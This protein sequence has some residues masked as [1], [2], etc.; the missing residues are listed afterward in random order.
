MTNSVGDIDIDFPSRDIALS[1][2]DYTQASMIKNENLEKHNTG[3]YFHYVP[4]DPVKNLCSIDYETAERRGWFKM[5]LLNVWVYEQVKDEKHLLDLLNREIDW[6]VFEQK[7]FVKRLIHLGNYSDLVSSLKPKNINEIAIIL[8]LIRPGKKHLIDRCKHKGFNSITNE[9]WL[10][11]EDREY[12]FK[13][14]HS[15]GYAALVKVHASLLIEQASE[16]T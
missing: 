13:K 1:V 14:S 15:C 5:D 6:K 11:P 7:E 8:A 3:V 16:S 10:E 9:I 4:V 2:L 12:H